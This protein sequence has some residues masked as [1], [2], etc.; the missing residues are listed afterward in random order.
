MRLSPLA[1]M[2]SIAVHGMAACAFLWGA[3]LFVTDPPG[4]SGGANGE[5][6][7][8]WL[9]GPKGQLI[10]QKPSQTTSTKR[11]VSERDSGKMAPKAA[12]GSGIGKSAG[13]GDGLGGKAGSGVG[14][15]TGEGVGSGRAGDRILT[16]IWK[17]IN[18]SKYYPPVAKRRGVEGA[19]RV[20]FAIDRDGQVKW[21]R[22]IDSCGRTVLDDAAIKTVRRAAPYPYYPSPITVAIRY[23][24]TD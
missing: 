1:I 22:L 24:L 20:T 4:G 17:R 16:S 2:I 19:P 5:V 3:H 6:V 14:R 7:T 15:G 9:A 8:V 18:R 11:G 21:A 23:S 10:G 13:V 12:L